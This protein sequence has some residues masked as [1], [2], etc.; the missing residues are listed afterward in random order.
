MPSTYR[1]R[2]PGHDYYGRGTYLITLV[3]SGRAP[4]LSHFVTD[5][6]HE[7]SHN[8]VVDFGHE[9]LSLTPL[10]KE[11]QQAWQ[12]TPVIQATHGNQV[13]VHACVC[14]PDH[15]HGVIEV[16]EPMEWNLGDIIQAFKA[17]CTSR[18]QQLQGLPPSTSRPISVATIGNNA[19]AWLLQKIRDHPDEG[20]LIR[21]L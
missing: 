3:V 8:P 12:Q 5:F 17:F 13:A 4:L 18:W 2:N 10:G 16:L 15:F 21:N 6:G 20:S 9:T 14:M 11:I 7:A 1:P 19:P